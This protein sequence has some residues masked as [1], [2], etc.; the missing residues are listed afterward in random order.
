MSITVHILL[1]AMRAVKKTGLIKGPDTDVDENLQK[2]REYNR[3]HPY[4]EPSDRKATYR[5]VHV[6]GYPCLV[7]GKTV[8]DRWQ[9]LVKSCG[10]SREQ[11]E[12]M[13]PAFFCEPGNL[14]TLHFTFDDLQALA[15][16]QALFLLSKCISL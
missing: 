10:L 13:A 6:G 16:M 5:T 4:K 9:Y 15:I 3:R 8:A 1:S 11:I 7:I 2:A 12:A 14:I